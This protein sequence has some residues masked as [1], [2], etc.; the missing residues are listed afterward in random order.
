M[1][2]VLPFVTQP[3]AVGQSKESLPGSAIPATVWGSVR[4]MSGHPVADVSIY[5]QANSGTEPLIV[6]TNSSGTYRFPA[7]REGVYTLHAERDGYNRATFGPW[8]LGPGQG[9]VVDL[10]LAPL[11]AST[12]E[13]SPSPTPP[14]TPQGDAGRGRKPEFFDEP[15][16]TVAGVTDSTSLGGHGSNVVAR[17]KDALAQETVSLSRAAPSTSQPAASV[18]SER[19]LRET[20]D[21][22]PQNFNANRQL[23]KVLVAE[24]RAADALPYLERAS[25]LNS[26]DSE[27]A[28]NLAR[29][30]A[31]AGKSESARTSIRALLA[32]PEKSVAQEAGLHHL[33]G[34]VEEK[35]GDSLA[36][37]REYQRAA[38]LD[39]SEEHLFD[40]GAELLVHRAAEPAVEVFSKGNRRFPRSTRLL[41]GLGV[42][43]YARG[44]YGQAAQCLCQASDLNPADPNPYVF[45]GKM[46]S[47]GTIASDCL[48][49]RLERFARLQ[50]E[51]APANYY[52]ALSLSKQRKSPVDIETLAQVEF[53]LKKAVQLDPKMSL[54]YLQL[55]MLYSDRNDFPQ[56]VSAYQKAIAAAP[57]LEEAHYRLAQTYRRTGEKLRAQQE[58]QMYQQLSRKTEEETKRQQHEIQQ[59]V[60]TLRDPA[61]ASQPQE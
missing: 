16:F 53:L 44:S 18:D 26:G 3:Q 42:A 20:A 35:Q 8:V 5:L 56:A 54:G 32:R 60:Y 48:A 59:F 31:A 6:R 41:V 30:Y 51:N 55:G 19:S 40:W 17:N 22:E 23:G 24:G 52:Y 28:Y 29:A 13:T 46:Q 38:E 25:R 36:A 2:L 7:L 37:V 11:K 43:W 45:I 4:D 34:D 33:L 12:Q 1:F 14:P 9:K 15:Q 10:M 61:S 58:L 27:N 57:E 49:Q 50:P 39:P 47:A 21:R